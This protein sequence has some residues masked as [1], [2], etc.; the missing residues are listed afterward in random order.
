MVEMGKVSLA[1]GI[2]NLLVYELEPEDDESY[3]VSTY[4]NGRESGFT[5]TRIN[6]DGKL[7]SV[8]FSEYRSSD[9]I[10]VYLD[11]R[12]FQGVSDESYKNAQFFNGRGK[13]GKAVEF[14]QKYL[15][16]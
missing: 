5:I 9:S 13:V 6:K 4:Q 14:C 12:D 11:N 1:I 3:C 16:K 10:V 2:L 15:T 7:S 8:T